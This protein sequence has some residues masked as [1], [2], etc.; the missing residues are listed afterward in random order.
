MDQWLQEMHQAGFDA[1][2]DGV[3]L[4]D[5]PFTAG[6]PSHTAWAT[7]HAQ[8]QQTRDEWEQA[9]NERVVHE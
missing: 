3:L 1:N 9:N 5:N 8:A 4:R 7:G 6:T 2:Y